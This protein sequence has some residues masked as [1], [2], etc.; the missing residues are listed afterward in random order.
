MFFV[1][2]SISTLTLLCTTRSRLP[3]CASNRDTGGVWSHFWTSSI[4]CIICNYRLAFS[5]TYKGYRISLLVLRCLL[6]E[7]EELLAL[8]LATWLFDFTLLCLN[9]RHGI[10]FNINK[11]L[12]SE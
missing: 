6:G 5:S 11:L 2:N 8:C 1:N 3:I 7:H 9:F 4:T 12:T 10:K